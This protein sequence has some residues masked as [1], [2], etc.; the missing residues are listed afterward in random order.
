[1]KMRLKKYLSAFMALLL[2]ISLGFSS[3]AFAQQYA[4]PDVSNFLSARAAFPDAVAPAFDVA[5]NDD[6]QAKSPLQVVALIG[7]AV[8]VCAAIALIII[9]RRKKEEKRLCKG[10]FWK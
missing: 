9:V 10:E 7:L 3:I 1:M 2:F 5:V 4:K 6:P 8:A